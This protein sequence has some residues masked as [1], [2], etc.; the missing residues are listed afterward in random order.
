ME[1][2]GKQASE[3]SGLL[4][5]VINEIEYQLTVHAWSIWDFRFCLTRPRVLAFF[6]QWVQCADVYGAN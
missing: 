6:E 2:G 3:E 4:C 1:R 5:T